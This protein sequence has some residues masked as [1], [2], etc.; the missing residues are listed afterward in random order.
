MHDIRYYAACVVNNAS[1]ARGTPWI[2]SPPFAT[3]AEA[4]AFIREV[5]SEG[6]LVFGCIVVAEGDE[7]RPLGV[8]RIWPSSASKAVGHFMDLLRLLKEPR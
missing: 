3:A 6:H 8:D 4:K 2:W 1:R 5:E 7:R